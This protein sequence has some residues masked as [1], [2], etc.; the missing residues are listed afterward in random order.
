MHTILISEK[1]KN[2]LQRRE[3][4]FSSMS[5]NSKGVKRDVW[6]KSSKPLPI[7][8]EKVAAICSGP[9]KKFILL[10]VREEDGVEYVQVSLE[11]EWL[12]W[13][14]TASG[15][16]ALSCNTSVAELIEEL[17]AAKKNAAMEMGTQKLAQRRLGIELRGVEFNVLNSTN[18]KTTWLELETRVRLRLFF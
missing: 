7:E 11:A 3:N 9:S 2:T 16:G 10:P 8:V 13:I 18:L 5:S 15:Q 4:T 6:P 14:V 12:N 17:N 1:I